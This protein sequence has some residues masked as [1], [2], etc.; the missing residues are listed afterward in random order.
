MLILEKHAVEEITLAL[1]TDKSDYTQ[2]E[3]H[4]PT[5]RMPA[6]LSVVGIKYFKTPIDPVL[7]YAAQLIKYSQEEL[8]L[9]MSIAALQKI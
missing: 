9:M 5:Q 3:Q 2:Q 8:F 7:K 1:V 4:S 6:V